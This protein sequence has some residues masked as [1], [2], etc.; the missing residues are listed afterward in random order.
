VLK[1]EHLRYLG[2]KLDVYAEFYCRPSETIVQKRAHSSI[3]SPMSS[4]VPRRTRTVQQEERQA[5]RRDRNEEAG[6]FSEQ[7][8]DRWMCLKDTCINHK[9]FCFVDYGGQHY[10]MDNTIRESWAKAISRG[11]TSV[12]RPPEV[13]YN[14]WVRKG[15]VNETCKAPLAKASREARE[16]AR[17]ARMERIFEMQEKAQEFA[18]QK[19]IQE[20]FSS[21]L[22]AFQA[23]ASYFSQ[24]QIPQYPPWIQTPLSFWPAPAPA[25]APAPFL[26]PAPVPSWSLP[27]TQ[28]LPRQGTSE[29]KATA[30]PLPNCRSSSPI[31]VEDELVLSDYWVWKGLQ[32]GSHAR[33]AQLASVC[34][35]VEE[36][37]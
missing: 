3:E 36:E 9:A 37:M 16:Q 5:E 17:D 19:Q 22:S 4:P 7:L 26:A 6:D 21:T 15:A 24:P 20:Q 33:K 35:I 14:F 11:N 18:M 25:P 23:P 29:Q 8:L 31:A 12:E 2:Y 32:T 34:E 28:I 30:A 10:S 27:P 1:E 13:L